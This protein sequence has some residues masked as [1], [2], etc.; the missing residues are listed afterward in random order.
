M[1]IAGKNFKFQANPNN[2]VKYSWFSPQSQGTFE[3]QVT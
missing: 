2:Q 1:G 3:I